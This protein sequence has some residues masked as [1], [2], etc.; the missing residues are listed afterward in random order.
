[1]SNCI[2]PGAARP[3]GRV[4]AGCPVTR[5]ISDDT[6]PWLFTLEQTCRLQRRARGLPTR[7]VVCL[8]LAGCLF[9]EL[10]YPQVW[11]RLTAGLGGLP[12]PVLTASA[13]TQARRRLGPGPLR[14]LF[15]LLRGPSAGEAP[16]RGLLACAIDGIIMAVADSAA[17]LAVCSKQRGGRGGASG[18]PMLR[19]LVLVSCGTRAVID[20]V[21]SPVSKGET[22]CAPGLL[23]SLH[24]GMIL[25]G[26]SG[27]LFDQYS[28]AHDH[29]VQPERHDALVVLPE[30]LDAADQMQAGDARQETIEDH[31]QLDAGQL[32]PDALMRSRAEGHVTHGVARDVEGVRL[33]EL[34]RVP[35]GHLG[36]GDD[37]FPSA[38]PYPGPLDIGH[39]HASPAEVR[40]GEEAQHLPNRAGEQRAVGA[41]P[42][43]LVGMQQ[44]NQCAQCRHAGR[45]VVAS[46][47]QQASGRDDL[48]VADPSLAGMADDQLA[49]Q[50]VARVALHSADFRTAD[51]ETGSFGAR[52]R[53]LT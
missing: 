24:A 7:V 48:L 21:F 44:Q 2:C 41:Q 29:L 25:L 51:T 35:I 31:L 18:Y 53:T 49:E 10:G 27:P 17:N 30:V 8:L 9:A 13:M 50:I 4:P 46:G 20:A 42:A 6:R 23:A 15:F 33:G 32:L 34:A 1:M 26:T 19:L 11:G 40:D 38:H 16:W 28:P 5:R 12:V 37:A 43:H 47:Q 39:R 45:G 36:V 14:E 52:Q 22:T 3:P